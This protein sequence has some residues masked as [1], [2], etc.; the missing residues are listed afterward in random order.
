MRNAYEAVPQD[1]T[2]GPIPQ[3]LCHRFFPRPAH[4]GPRHSPLPFENEKA[5]PRDPAVLEIFL[6]ADTPLAYSDTLP[7]ESLSLS[8]ASARW[9]T[10]GI[11]YSSISAVKPHSS[12]NDS[13]SSYRKPSS[14]TP[15]PN[16]VAIYF[17]AFSSAISGSAF[18]G[19]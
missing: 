15:G 5:G 6:G 10:T 7:V 2:D 17:A 11:A 18:A 16:D 9:C 1:R 19:A 3:S 8:R 13:F 4:S 12:R 14:P